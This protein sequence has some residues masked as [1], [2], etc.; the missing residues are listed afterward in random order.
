MLKRVKLAAPVA[1]R[2]RVAIVASEYNRKH[3]D[4]LL[5]AAVHG[6]RTTGAE[7]EV[8]RVPGAFEIPVAAESLLHEA[9]GR[10]SALICLGV[11]I[12][13]ETAHADLVGTTVTGALM[14]IAVRHRVPVIHEVLLVAN[15]S[16][17]DARCLDARYN[18][19][20]EAARSALAMARL[21]PRL[22]GGRKGGGGQ[23]A[24]PV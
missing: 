2:A 15:Q 19:G 22:R 5:D 1:S 20:V 16:Q 23:R 11:I 9:R 18:R 10:W 6:L 12:R 17:A 14:G 7:V 13:G 4:G 3:V 21:M 8:F 24:R